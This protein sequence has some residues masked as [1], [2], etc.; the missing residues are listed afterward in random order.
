MNVTLATPTALATSPRLS[1]EDRALRVALRQDWKRQHDAKALTPAMIA[2]YALLRGKSIAKAFTPISRPSK[3]ANGHR[4]TGAR[5]DAL[6]SAALLHVSAWSP[7]A[8]RLFDPKTGRPD[9]SHPAIVAAL[10]HART[11]GWTR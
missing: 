10:A 4:A 3:L 8:D 2:A 6:A 9:P 1:D 5:D 11:Q 7:F